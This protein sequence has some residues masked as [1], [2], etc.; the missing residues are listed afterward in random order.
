ML[1]A[2]LWVALAVTL[3]SGTMMARAQ[4]PADAASP[5]GLQQL[6][7]AGS[8]AMGP[9]PLDRDYLNDA[10]L[11][12]QDY[13]TSSGATVP[14]PNLV[15]PPQAHRSISRKEPRFNRRIQKQDEQWE[16]S[17]CSNC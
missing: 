3:A 10:R 11:L 12:N 15:C 2:T 14:C 1:K 16:R 4:I 13:L 8:E 7:P 5:K 6:K 9:W 17:I